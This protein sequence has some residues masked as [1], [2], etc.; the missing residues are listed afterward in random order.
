MADKP[1]LLDRVRLEIRFRH[2]SYRTEQQYVAW[3]RRFILFHDKRH[4]LS[5]GEPEVTS[6]L[7]HLASDRNV[8]AATQAQALA[9]LLFLYRHVLRVDLPWVEG[10]VRARRPKRLPVVLTRSEVRRTLALMPDIYGLV[11]SVLYGGGLRLSEGLNLR[12]KDVDLDRRTLIVR[13][14]KGAKDRVTVI[15]DRLCTVLAA[16][17]VRVKALHDQ[18]HFH[19]YAGVELPHALQRKYPG[20]H[21]E[22]AWQFVF[23]ASQPSRDP[24]T[25]L[26]RRHHL[27]ADNL[28]RHFKQAL[29][30]ARV[31]KPASSHSL[32]HSFATHLLE[33]G[34][35]I[36]T[37]QELLGHASVKTTQL[38]T[39]V[40]NRGGLAVRSPLDLPEP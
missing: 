29:R 40:L 16:H 14:G 9:A 4:P 35:D 37:V 32:R 13:N 33:S 21:L 7:S 20:A 22:W 31:E 38:Y 30:N 3:I 39:H 1:R 36:R 8:A 2:Y 34:A 12:I 18:A 25:G 19:G 26:W 5:M 15:P 6:F 11:A 24:R 10:F 28:Q 17:L 27:N 23:P